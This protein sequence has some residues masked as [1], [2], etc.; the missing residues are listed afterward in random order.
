[1][2]CWHSGYSVIGPSNSQHQQVP[3]CSSNM[4]QGTSS[5]PP[6]WNWVRVWLPPWQ[7]QHPTFLPGTPAR[8]FLVPRLA[9]GG[10]KPWCPTILASRKQFLGA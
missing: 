9:V 5:G 1:M 3:A 8:S 4:D 7:K 10:H 6:R 2:C